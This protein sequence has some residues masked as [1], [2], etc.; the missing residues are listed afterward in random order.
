MLAVHLTL[1]VSAAAMSVAAVTPAQMRTLTSIAT[2]RTTL[3]SLPPTPA[4]QLDTSELRQAAASLLTQLDALAP[5]TLAGLDAPPPRLEASLLEERL[6][7]ELQELAK[8]QE[9]QDEDRSRQLFELIDRSNDGLIQLDEFLGAAPAIFAPGVLISDQQL[10]QMERLFH[11]VDLDQSGELDLGEFTRLIGS[12]KGEMASVLIASREAGL[13]RL[14]SLTLDVCGL[15]LARELS[16]VH[17]SRRG[18]AM[19]CDM[20]GAVVR[21]CAMAERAAAISATPQRV[22]GCPGEEVPLEH[23][24]AL[25]AEARALAAELSGSKWTVDIGRHARLAVAGTRA[26]LRFGLRGLG[27]MAGDVVKAVRFLGRRLRG[28]TLADAELAVIRRTV[29]DWLCL[30]PYTAILVFPLTP[31]GNVLAFNLLSRVAP[32]STPSGFTRRRQ[33]CDEM[34]TEVMGAAGDVACEWPLQLSPELRRPLV[35]S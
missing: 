11:R 10:E 29:I 3:V 7:E 2:M 17:A 12:L 21:W 16:V 25:A 27:I 31:P 15:A 30:V 5:C 20:E 18:R 28:Q 6:D 8:V 23:L 24:E 22:E 9:Q 19:L 4:A 26:S 34:F 1:I 14:I 33:D 32:W 13:R 35:S